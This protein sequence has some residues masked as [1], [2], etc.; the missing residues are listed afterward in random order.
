VRW[1]RACPR[2]VQDLH[3]DRH[4]D[5]GITNPNGIV[6]Y[7][8]RGLPD[9]HDRSN[10]MHCHL[11]CVPGFSR[12]L[13]NR[14]ALRPLLF[15]GLSGS[16]FIYAGARRTL[17]YWDIKPNR[18]TSAHRTVPPFLHRRPILPSPTRPSSTAR[19]SPRQPT[20]SPSSTSEQ[21]STAKNAAA[22]PDA[23][24]PSRHTSSCPSRSPSRALCSEPPTRTASTLMT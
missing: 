16:C 2:A 12:L 23:A 22:A 9:L 5:P 18:E 15:C 17:F 6:F 24:R 3:R 8:H 4:T 11:V 13:R 1:P 7:L 21:S 14:P 10:G 19:P 20:T